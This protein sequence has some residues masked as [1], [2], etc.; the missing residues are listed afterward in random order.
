MRHAQSRGVKRPNRS[1]RLSVNSVAHGNHIPNP[2]CPAIPHCKNCSLRFSLA[3][4]SC[5]YLP[6]NTLPDENC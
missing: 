1:N 6:I 3:D 2:E 4:S 5:D